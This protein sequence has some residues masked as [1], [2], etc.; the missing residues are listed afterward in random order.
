MASGGRVRAGDLAC[1]GPDTI[2]YFRNF[3][4]DKAFLG[5]GGIS[6]TV[7]L[8]DYHVNEI[9]VRQVILNQTRECYVLADSTKLGQVAVG[10]VCALDQITAIITDTD[11]DT[12]ELQALQ[13]AGVRVL[14]APL[15]K[16]L[17]A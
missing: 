4:P 2:S 12:N 17:A 13:D 11:A 16:V 1:S 6:A 9:A 7:G 14:L 8:T 3:Y 10:R 15:P 5:S